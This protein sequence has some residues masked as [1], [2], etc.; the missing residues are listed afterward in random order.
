M[1]A[2][3]C[4]GAEEM[5]L[6]WRR[7]HPRGHHRFITGSSRRPQGVLKGSSSGHLGAEDSEDVRVDGEALVRRARALEDPQPLAYIYEGDN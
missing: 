7:R 4:L 6:G 3:S 1:V 5:V 2:R